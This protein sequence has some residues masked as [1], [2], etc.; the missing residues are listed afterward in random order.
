LQ[1]KTK[2]HTRHWFVHK[3]VRGSM[4]GIAEHCYETGL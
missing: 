2:T 4:S 3:L 1:E